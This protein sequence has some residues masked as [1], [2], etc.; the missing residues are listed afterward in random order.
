MP[1]LLRS[2]VAAEELKVQQPLSYPT[3]YSVVDFFPFSSVVGTNFT[4]IIQLLV[5]LLA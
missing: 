2:I 4:N 3:Q 1:H 5:A